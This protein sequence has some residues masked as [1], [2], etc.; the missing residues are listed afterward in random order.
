MAKH[1]ETVDLLSEEFQSEPSRP[2]LIP[3]KPVPSVKV[4]YDSVWHM[5]LL[6][7]LFQE[8]ILPKN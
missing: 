6:L 5:I 1:K 4:A 3:K 8:Q 7:A 2:V